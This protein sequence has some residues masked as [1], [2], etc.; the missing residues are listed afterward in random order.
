MPMKFTPLKLAMCVSLL[1][2]GGVLSAYYA[3]QQVASKQR[4]EFNHELALEIE[5]ISEPMP[6][7]AA[8]VAKPAVVPETLLPPVEPSPVVEMKPAVSEEVKVVVPEKSEVVENDQPQT[9]TI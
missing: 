1:V 2:H 7:A 3:V 8:V 9:R 5:I 6:V 4:V